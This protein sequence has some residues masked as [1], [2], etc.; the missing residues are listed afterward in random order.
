[1]YV[2]TYICTVCGTQFRLLCCHCP[3]L[4][5]F[6]TQEL[7]ADV[8][9]S[10]RYYETNATRPDVVQQLF[11]EII[12][13]PYI[14]E[15]VVSVVRGCWVGHWRHQLHMYVRICVYIHV[16]ML[17][18][19]LVHAH[20]HIRT[21]VHTCTLHTHMNTYMH[22]QTHTRTHTPPKQSLLH[23]S[24]YPVIIAFLPHQFRATPTDAEKFAVEVRF[25]LVCPATTVPRSPGAYMGWS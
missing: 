17:D 19:T 2:H 25:H 9:G 8:G 7:S 22:I 5:I 10:V 20:T 16:H 21:R 6:L 11:L 24:A 14:N 13:I 12:A 1:M 3:C 18:Q 4:L 15:E 23:T